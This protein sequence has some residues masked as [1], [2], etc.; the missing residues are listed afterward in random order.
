MISNRFNIVEEK[1]CKLED[2]SNRNYKKWNQEENTEKNEQRISSNKYN[3]CITRFSKRSEDERR[4]NIWR[5]YKEIQGRS[6]DSGGIGRGDHFL[7]YKFIE[8]TTEWWT[9]FT[10]QLLIASSGHQAPRKAAHCLRRE[11]KK[12]CFFSFFFFFFFL[13]L[14]F[15]SFFFS[16]FSFSCF[17]LPFPFKVL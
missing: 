12:F 13:F 17:S 9:K 10:K 5:I 3:I 4:K 15:F 14:F 6:Q 7:F 2:I 1:I 16:F 8:R 11:G